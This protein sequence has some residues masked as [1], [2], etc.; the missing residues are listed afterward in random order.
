MF[1]KPKTHVKWG[2]NYILES[3]ENTRLSGDIKHIQ[4][5]DNKPVC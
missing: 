4:Q 1:Y 5:Y 3:I 2:Q